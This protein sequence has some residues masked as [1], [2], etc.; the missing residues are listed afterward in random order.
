MRW[1]RLNLSSNDFEAPCGIALAAY[2]RGRTSLIYLDVSW[3][4]LGD[5]GVAA[6]AEVSPQ[7][8]PVVSPHLGHAASSHP[9]TAACFV[10]R[11]KRVKA[12]CS[13][14]ST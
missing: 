9:L 14:S 10:R 11:S 3:N 13:K 6:I 5:E 12:A 8:K 2:L 7:E 4:S 1:T